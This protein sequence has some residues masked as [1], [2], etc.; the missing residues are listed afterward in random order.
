MKKCPNCNKR[1]NQNRNLCNKCY[2]LIPENREKRRIW[3][4][5]YRRKNLEYRRKIENK[6]TFKHRYGITKFDF[7]EIFKK[8][9]YKCKICGKTQLDLK[10]LFHLDHNHKNFKIRGILCPDCNKGL[11]FFSD[12][13]NLL[14]K[15]VGYLKN[16]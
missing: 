15:A 9:Q 5:N 3:Q 4:K 12:D 2:F 1:H 11:G 6:S 13:I 8:Q 10:Q 14:Q 16:S 7:E